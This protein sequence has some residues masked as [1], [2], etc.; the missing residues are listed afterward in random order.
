M[1]MC[2]NIL[3][4]S[5]GAVGELLG[6]IDHEGQAL[7]GSASP[8]LQPQLSLPVHSH[9]GSSCCKLPALQTKPLFEPPCLPFHNGLHPLS[10]VCDLQ[11]AMDAAQYKMVDLPKTL[12]NV[13]N[14]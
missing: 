13:V 14:L 7:R 11:R 12:Q 6:D 2:L 1:F 5:G 4:S 10:D 8:H 3:A 9:D